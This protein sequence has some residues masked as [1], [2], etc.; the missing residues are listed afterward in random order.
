ML[1]FRLPELL[2]EKERR[3]GRRIGWREVS[4][5]TGISR[6][7]LANLAARGRSVVTNTAYLE[8]LCRYFGRGPQDLL[9]FV[10]PIDEEPR[11]HVD[12]LYPERRRPRE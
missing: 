2:L 6:Q 5:A 10:P 1:Q 4:E 9:E 8:A 7:V 11:H 12:E 3:E